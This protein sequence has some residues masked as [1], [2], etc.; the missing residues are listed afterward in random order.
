[1]SHTGEV[2][3]YAQISLLSTNTIPDFFFR[4]AT[5]K[6][7]LSQWEC[8][9]EV[10]CCSFTTYRPFIQIWLGKRYSGLWSSSYSCWY[11]KGWCSG[12]SWMD[13]WQQ[14][15][16]MCLSW[17]SD[18]SLW[19]WCSSSW[20]MA[21][22]SQAS[23]WSYPHQE[24]PGSPKSNCKALTT[25]VYSGPTWA[26]I[27]ADQ[28]WYDWHKEDWY[29]KIR[30]NSPTESSSTHFFFKS[31]LHFIED[32]I[33]PWWEMGFS[34]TEVVC[35]TSVLLDA[36]LQ[37]FPA[38]RTATVYYVSYGNKSRLNSS[39]MVSSDTETQVLSYFSSLPLNSAH[40]SHI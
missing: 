32:G 14:S 7:Q 39:T 2:R 34:T 37:T 27:S 15:F 25:T 31:T 11:G 38:D 16:N 26:Q 5:F 23:I 24:Q 6:H 12:S 40:R 19:A 22:V 20:N 36:V 17:S 28:C 13:P 3:W 1:M 33:I 18:Y 9:L 35:D 10:P 4:W 29:A 21:A 8:C 30:C